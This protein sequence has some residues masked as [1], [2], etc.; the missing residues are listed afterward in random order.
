M[1]VVEIPGTQPGGAG[2]ILIRAWDNRWGQTFDDG[3][4]PSGQVIVTLQGLGG[5]G[6]PPP[7]LGTAGDFKGMTMDLL[8]RAGSALEVTLTKSD[9][10]SVSVGG[11]GIF[12]YPYRI[13]ASTNLMDWVE[14]GSTTIARP[15]VSTDWWNPYYH[16]GHLQ[17]TF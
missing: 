13:W 14:S 1:G 16:S 8:T 9:A 15:Q 3:L 5:G 6:I 10:G 2:K 12:R 4:K 7:G 17:W 11:I